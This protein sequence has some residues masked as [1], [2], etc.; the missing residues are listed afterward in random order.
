MKHGGTVFWMELCAN[1][2]PMS[3][4]LDNLHKVGGRVNANTLHAITLKLFLIP[5]IE[6]IAMAMAFPD[7]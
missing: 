6:F 3:G 7:E 5:V 2:P 1:I 4:N